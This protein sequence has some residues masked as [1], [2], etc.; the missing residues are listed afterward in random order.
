MSVANSPLVKTAIAGEDPNW[1]RIIMAIGKSGAQVERD[2]ISIYFG[3]LFICFIGKRC[4]WTWFFYS[5]PA[6]HLLFLH[7]EPKLIH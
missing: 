2:K 3:D 4:Y 7:H 5:V 1:G 6:F